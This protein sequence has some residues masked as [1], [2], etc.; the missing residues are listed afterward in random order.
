MRGI[1]SL[2]L[3]PDTVIP[4]PPRV[5]SPAGLVWL[6][7]FPHLPWRLSLVVTPLRASRGIFAFLLRL[8]VSFVQVSHVNEV[9]G[10]LSF[11]TSV[12]LI[13]S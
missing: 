6:S 11:V 13:H 12:L 1:G 5:G 3:S 9:T 7:R 10:H 8:F 4:P 2:R